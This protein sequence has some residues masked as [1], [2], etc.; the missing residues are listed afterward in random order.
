MNADILM[1]LI[2]LP[3]GIMVAYV[4]MRGLYRL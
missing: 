1:P 4:V 2:L 3:F